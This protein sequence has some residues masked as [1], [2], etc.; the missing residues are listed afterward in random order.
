M[1]NVTVSDNFGGS[2]TVHFVFNQG[3]QG[4]N[5]NLTGTTGNDVIFGTGNS[6]TLTGNGGEDQ[7]VFAPTSGPTAAQHTITD[8]NTHLDTIDLRQFTNINTTVDALATAAQQGNDTLLRIDSQDTILLKN[9]IAANLH[10]SD[11]IVTPH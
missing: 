4:P 3:G 1:V 11:F 2:E 9:V 8:F 7:F 6:D 10:A 5:I